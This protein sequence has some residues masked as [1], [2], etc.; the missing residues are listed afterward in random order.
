MT[1]LGVVNVGV[2]VVVVRAVAVR[3]AAAVVRRGAA[4]CR[5]ATGW[6]TMGCRGLL[7]RGGLS[8]L[9]AVRCRSPR[10]APAAYGC[11]GASVLCW[12]CGLLVGVLLLRWV[13]WCA[14]RS[15]HWGSSAR[16][17]S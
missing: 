8:R 4:A 7:G 11:D 16:P 6:V 13:L 1:P 5:V 2:E 10:R 17:L 3:G 9:A 12:P 14:G 15:R